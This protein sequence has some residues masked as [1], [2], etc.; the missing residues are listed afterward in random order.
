MNVYLLITL[1]TVLAATAAMMAW[2]D[3]YANGKRD[4]RRRADDRIAGILDR[5]HNRRMRGSRK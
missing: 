4:E 1:G 2:L 5:E 3:G